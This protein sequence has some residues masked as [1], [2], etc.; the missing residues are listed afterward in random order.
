[1]KKYLLIRKKYP[2]F[3]YQGYRFWLEN[4]DLVI[5]FY[6]DLPNDFKFLHTIKIKDIEKEKIKE[7]PKE[8]LENLIFNLGIAE[9]L[10]YWKLF[11]S[12][13][14]FIPNYLD[15][16]QVDFWE[17]F[18]L[19]GMGQY[20]YENKINFKENNF[21]NFFVGQTKK[22]QKDK[23]KLLPNFLLALGEGKDSIVSLELFKKY[24]EENF[25]EKLGI[26]VVNPNLLHLSI[27]S[28]SGV[29]K[30][31]FV[32]RKLDNQILKLNQL[33]YLNGHIPITGILSFLISLCGVIFGYQNL[34]FSNERSSEEGN[35]K[36]LK[37]I[38]NHQWSKSYEFENLFREYLNS[39]LIENINFFSFLRPLYEI[40]IAKIF[41]KFPQYF[42]NF[43]SC[44]IVKTNNFSDKKIKWCGKCPKCLFVFTM[45]YGFLGKNKVSEIFGKNLFEDKELIEL[46]EKLLGLKSFK[47]FECL[48]TVRENRAAFYLALQKAKKEKDIPIVLKSLEKEILKYKKDLS[49]LNSWSDSNNLPKELADFLKKEINYDR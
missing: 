26:F 32:E 6:Y 11:C 7:T 36:Y 41:T 5:N 2:N 9:I 47:P 23:A 10:N 14:I 42:N 1:M 17:K 28:Q 4:N 44:N 29:K 27:I 46:S 49:I 43:S 48:G 45:L 19:R 39:Y 3:Y 22:F 12:Q 24:F 25:Q 18:F 33:G 30:R 31:I 38:I 8:T 16:K 40:Q 35:T 13:N 15:R 20:F 34:V 21:I 37:E